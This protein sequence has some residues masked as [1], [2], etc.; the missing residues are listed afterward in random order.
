MTMLVACGNQKLSGLRLARYRSADHRRTDAGSKALAQPLS[1]RLFALLSGLSAFLALGV[2]LYV[3][4]STSFGFPIDAQ[5]AQTLA[6]RILAIRIF[7][8]AF[9]LSLIV[10]IFFAGSRTARSAL[11]LRWILGIATSVPFLRGIGV[12]V[13]YGGENAAI[14]GLAIVQPVMEG[15]AILLLYGEDARDWFGQQAFSH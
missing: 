2:A 11:V 7:G 1:I 9:A 12:V 6:A 4:K 15:L 14:I 5:A 3:A 10:A 8:F 13:A